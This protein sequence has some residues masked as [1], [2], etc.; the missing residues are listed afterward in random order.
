MVMTPDDFLAAYHVNPRRA[1]AMARALGTKTVILAVGLAAQSRSPQHTSYHYWL[2]RFRCPPLPAS[3]AGWSW[4]ANG[5]L[6]HTQNRLT[7][8]QAGEAAI[9]MAERIMAALERPL[10]AK[11]ESWSHW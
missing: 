4:T 9:T 2:W 7:I 5:D 6:H 8:H 10:V 1:C 3:L 11:Q